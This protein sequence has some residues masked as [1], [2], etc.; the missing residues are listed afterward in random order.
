MPKRKAQD[1][2][3]LIKSAIPAMPILNSV[4]DFWKMLQ[5]GNRKLP[6][7]QF[8]Q[9]RVLSLIENSNQRHSQGHFVLERVLFDEKTAPCYK[10]LTISAFFIDLMTN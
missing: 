10:S 3:G 9:C 7:S 5:I 1:M 6:I 2:F 8:R 4:A